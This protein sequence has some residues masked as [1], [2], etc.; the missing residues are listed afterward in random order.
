MQQIEQNK[1]DCGGGVHGNND[2]HSNNE[3]NCGNKD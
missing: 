2:G 1:W 3:G